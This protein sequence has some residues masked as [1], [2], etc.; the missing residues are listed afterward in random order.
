MSLHDKENEGKQYG[1]VKYRLD[2]L[3]A[4]RN[5]TVEQLAELTHMNPVIL[6]RAIA[7][8][9]QP[10]FQQMARICAA[11]GI[12]ACQLIFYEPPI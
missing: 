10:S 1:V 9:T 2:D 7:G 8:E 12:G 11:L 5:M 3:L 4:E 6:K